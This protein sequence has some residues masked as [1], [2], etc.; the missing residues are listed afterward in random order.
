MKQIKH[1]WK[2]LL[3]LLLA[4]MLAGALFRLRHTR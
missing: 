4:A 3:P 2:I 1:Q